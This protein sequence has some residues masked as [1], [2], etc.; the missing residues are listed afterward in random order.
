MIRTGLTA[1]AVAMCF[2]GSVLA[3]QQQP[4]AAPPP[5]AFS[6]VEI[7]TTDV[8]DGIYMMEG[9]MLGSIGGNITV[10]LA[11]DG[12]SEDDVVAAKPFADKP[13][14]KKSLLKRIL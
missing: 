1:I 6:K 11:K 9:Q 3:Q 12:K 14:A 13:E 5:V 8:G 10:A 7:K 2:G 4:P